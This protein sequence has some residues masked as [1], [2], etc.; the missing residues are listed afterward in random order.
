VDQNRSGETSRTNLPRAVLTRVSTGER[1]GVRKD[2]TAGRLEDCEI[3]LTDLGTSRNHARLSFV[4]DGLWVEDLGSANGTFVNDVRIAERVQLKSSDRLRFNVEEF[5]V[6]LLALPGSTASA[7]QPPLK[8][9]STPPQPVRKPAPLPA[10][11]PIAV[12]APK[13]TPP[14]T[15]EPPRAAPAVEPPPVAASVVVPP[16]VEPPSVE[17][18]SVEP[19]PVAASVAPPPPVESSPP[20]PARSSPEEIGAIKRPGAWAHS[21]SGIQGG[22]TGKS[23]KY[24]AP[25]EIKQMMASVQAPAAATAPDI[26][27]PYLQIL[28]GT[29]IGVNVPLRIGA[30]GAT[31]WSVGSDSERE[32]VLSDEGVSAL[33]ARVVNEG[34]RWKIVDQMSANGTFVNGKRSSVSYVSEGDRLLFGSVECIFHPQVS[35][36]GRS[37]GGQ[38]EAG[39]KTGGMSRRLIGVIAGVVAAAL[40]AAAY[41]MLR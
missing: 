33:H 23:T 4:D 34:K 11:M 38:R 12:P 15:V 31:E 28:S 24:L 27:G 7:S 17:P 35:S 9:A 39:A 40:L 2:V 20:M 29:R 1:L 36:T 10:T 22:T 30:A 3:V 37:S 18:P 32:V 16:S 5:V 41:A 19:P 21:L 6:D 25:A 8:V 26:D 13:L 14:L